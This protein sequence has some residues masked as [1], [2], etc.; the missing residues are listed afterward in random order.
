MP[1]GDK[2]MGSMKRLAED[3]MEDLDAI[4]KKHKMTP[5]E[6]ISVFE[7]WQEHNEDGWEMKLQWTNKTCPCKSPGGICEYPLNGL[8]S[9]RLCRFDTCPDESKKLIEK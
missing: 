5:I 1:K 3:I 6:L 7:L 8:P 2:D 9:H 4:V